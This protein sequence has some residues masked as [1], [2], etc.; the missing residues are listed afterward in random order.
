MELDD[1]GDGGVGDGE[2]RRARWTRDDGTSRD[3]RNET[4]FPDAD[5][6]ADAGAL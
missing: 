1:D 3:G 2:R 4:R 6:D 5:A